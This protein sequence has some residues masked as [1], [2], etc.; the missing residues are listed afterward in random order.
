MFCE[1]VICKVDYS[2]IAHKLIHTKTTT[3]KKLV[4]TF[5]PSCSSH[6]NKI[7]W[8]HWS[9]P[10]TPPF[11]HHQHCKCIIFLVQNKLRYRERNKKYIW[12]HPTIITKRNA[13][14]Q[15][16]YG[17]TSKKREIG[18]QMG[19]AAAN[20]CLSVCLCAGPLCTGC[21]PSIKK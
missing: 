9:Y 14:I 21:E 7:W 5:V 8:S 4:Y 16:P 15:T 11:H 1:W 3:T 19:Q 12:I 6:R 20:F 18:M 17:W 2:P 13:S 10:T